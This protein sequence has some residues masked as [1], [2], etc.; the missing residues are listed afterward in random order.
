MSASALRTSLVPLQGSLAGLLFPAL[1]SSV[2]FLRAPTAAALIA[3]R[4]SSL[5][6]GAIFACMQAS[7]DGPLSRISRA[8]ATAW[9]TDTALMQCGSEERH[10]ALHASSPAAREILL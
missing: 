2:A 9:S 1:G 4:E 5:C 8:A 3:G 7:K 6:G 10:S